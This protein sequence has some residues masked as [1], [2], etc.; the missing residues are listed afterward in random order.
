MKQIN[1]DDPFVFG[2]TTFGKWFTDREKDA[3]RLLGNFTHGIN[4][5]II[6]PRRWGKTS[7]VCKV[8][9]QVDD[10]QLKIVAMDVFACRS[11]ED[12]YQTFAT[13]IIKQTATKWEEWVKNAQHFLS[14]LVPKISFGADPTMDFSLSLDFSNKQLNQDVMHL[15]QK[16]A[17]EKN[18]RIVVCIDEFQ[19]ISEFPDPKTFQKKLRSAW[20]LQ[21]QHV[22]YCL[23]GSKKHLLTALFSKQSMP[24]YKFGDIL[25]L[26]KIATDNWIQYIQTRFKETGKEISSDLAAKI[27]DKVECH[28]SYVQ[29]FAWLVWIRTE[30]TAKET[31]FEAALQD[32]L[33]QNSALFYNYT[34][35]LTALQLNFMRAIADGIHDQFSRNEIISKYNLGTS[36]NISRIKKSLEQKELI[37]VSPHNIT[38]NDPVFCIWFKKMNI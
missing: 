16:I 4:T 38:F 12:F 24:F 37:D 30:K 9:D 35:T 14:S 20:Q 5:I 18:I 31:D 13:E 27:C 19:Q 26:Q 10:K 1:M 11:E 25:F 23:Y 36:S 28:S 15:P 21:T 3:K 17:I 6:S 33:N 22:S 32:L 34:E 2:S 8:A 29:Q 7:L